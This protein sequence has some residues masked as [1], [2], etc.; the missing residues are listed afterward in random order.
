[1]PDV[2]MSHPDRAAATLANVDD[3]RA[4]RG[5]GPFQAPGAGALDARI[6]LKLLQWRAQQAAAASARARERLACFD[7][8]QHPDLWAG[9]IQD[10]TARGFAAALEEAIALAPPPATRATEDVPPPTVWTGKELRKKKDLLVASGGARVRFSRKEGVLLVDRDGGVHSKNCVRFEARADRGTLDGFVADDAERPRLYSA[11]FLQPQRYVQGPRGSALVLAGRLGRGPI[12][13][14]CEVELTGSADESSVGMVVRI[15]HEIPGFR[16]RIRFLGIAST[17]IAHECTP[18]R[19]VVENDA[20]GFVAFTLVRACS[21][22]LV[23]GTA[24]A[25]PGALCL[26]TIEHRFRL[27]AQD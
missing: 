15:D 7:T 8:Q 19:E 25:V 10:G 17:A 18:V 24:V 5:S 12:G 26:G 1:M 14:P 6:D 21:T 3:Q 4:H 23:D 20:G 22:L 2:T 9:T 16:L 13:W 11:Q 27:G